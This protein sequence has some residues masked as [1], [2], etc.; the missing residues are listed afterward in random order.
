MGLNWRSLP[1]HEK[2]MME[3]VVRK[4]HLGDEPRDVE[5]WR[6]KTPQERLEALELIRR[7]YITRKYGAVQ[8]LQRVWRVVKRG[9]Q[10]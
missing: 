2:G 7:E 10:P 1:E 5:Y 3:K 8:G 9:E 6:T 4:Y